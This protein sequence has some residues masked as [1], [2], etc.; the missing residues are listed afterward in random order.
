MSIIRFFVFVF[1][2]SF[3]ATFAWRV[4]VI[5]GVPIPCYDFM[6][7]FKTSVFVFGIFLALWSFKR[8]LTS[9]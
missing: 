5:V 9:N 4:F 2:M 3:V 6:T 8:F 1:F 7:V